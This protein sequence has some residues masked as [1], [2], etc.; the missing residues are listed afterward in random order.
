MLQHITVPRVGE[1]GELRVSQL[2]AAAGSLCQKGQTVA[3]LDTDK[4]ALEIEAP[5]EGTLTAWLVE[6]GAA[7]QPGQPIATFLPESEDDPA[8]VAFSVPAKSAAQP[9]HRQSRLKASPVARRMAALSGVDLATLG[10]TGYQGRVVRRDVAAAIEEIEQRQLRSARSPDTGSAEAVATSGPSP[11]ADGAERQGTD[12]P[13]HRSKPD[14]SVVVDLTPVRRAIA[15]RLSAS[16]GPVPHFYLQRTTHVSDTW[17]AFKQLQAWRKGLSWSDVLIASVARTLPSHPDLNASWDGDQLL[18]HRHVN[19]G[20]AVAA[21]HGLVTVVVKEAEALTLEGIAA[22]RQALVE[23]ARGR[24]LRH[25]DTIGATFTLS[26]L[27]MFGIDSFQAIISP[28]EAAILAVGSADLRPV[29][30]EGAVSVG[31]TLTLSLS[32]DHRVADGAAAARFLD[33]LCR[34]LEQPLALA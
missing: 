22:A 14:G 32:V 5:A 4:A 17:Q 20:L 16:L 1:T 2:Q 7:V 12:E 28:P 26:N 18:R 11:G 15:K 3:V 34:R 6:E 23:R 10:G 33:E 19:I 24:R 30:R 8:S 21:D 29:V 31:R 9:G 27:G 13:D 25:E